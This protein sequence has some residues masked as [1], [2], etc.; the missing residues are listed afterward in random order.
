MGGRAREGGEEA[1]LRLS[2]SGSDVSTAALKPATRQESGRWAG[3]RR[4]VRPLLPLVRA[5]AQPLTGIQQS[6]HRLLPP[7][8]CTTVHDR[9]G[10]RQRRDGASERVRGDR[11]ATAVVVR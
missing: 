4:E 11:E 10:E 1:E 2:S 8:A 6:H 9:G 3:E 7:N 5:L